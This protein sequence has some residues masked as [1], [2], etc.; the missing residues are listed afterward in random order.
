MFPV[1]KVKN[2]SMTMNQSV[3]DEH[4]NPSGCDDALLIDELPAAAAAAAIG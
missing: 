4:R 3:S 2:S 1:F